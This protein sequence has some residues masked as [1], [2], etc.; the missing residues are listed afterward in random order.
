MSAFVLDPKLEA[1]TLHIADI[2]L[3]ELRLMN[4]KRFPWLILIP[5]RP[6]VAELYE[7]SP[8]DQTMLTFEASQISQMLRKMTGA[9][10]MNIAA[11]GNQV[12]QLHIHVIARFEGDS[13]W[14]NPVYF[15]PGQ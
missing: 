1:D 2:G 6:D 15:A 10:K 8:L 3:T 12:R 5:K 13:A 11:L 14:P 9:K 4:D 7:L